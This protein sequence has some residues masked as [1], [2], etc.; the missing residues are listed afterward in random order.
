MAW[1]EVSAHRRNIQAIL[2]RRHKLY[3][4]SEKIM[5]KRKA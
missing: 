5:L 1:L 4:L 3:R 2:D